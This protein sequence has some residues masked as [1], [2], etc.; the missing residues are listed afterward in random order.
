MQPNQ[1]NEP[2]NDFEWTV[3]KR[4][5]G[6]RVDA[7]LDTQLPD[8][9]R[10]S[11]RRLIDAGHLQRNGM[12]PKPHQKL[13]DGD[14]LLLHV[15]QIQSVIPQAEAIP[16]DLLFEDDHIAVLNKAPGIVVH[17]AP[18]HDRGTLV[19]ALLHRFPQLKASEANMRP[20]IVHRLDRDTSGVLIVALTPL[21]TDTLMQQFKSGQIEK[22][23]DA[24]VSGCPRP[25]NGRIESLIARHPKD[26]KRMAVSDD[27]GKLAITEF[28]LREAFSDGRACHLDIRIETGRT[29]QIRVHMAKRGHPILG[30]T[31]YARRRPTPWPDRQMLH[32]REISFH[33]PESRKRLTFSAPAADD[34]RD[35]IDQLRAMGKS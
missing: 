10:S 31:I 23:Y 29:H 14:H 13:Q 30:D 9:S 5:T 27:H 17:P 3:D 35:M 33:H 32:A 6:Q 16:L 26:R 28:T 20:G 8:H 12:H 15:P 18:G 34:M 4:A 21:A 7:W 19:N 2:K 11:I 22:R 1:K 25:P 24:I